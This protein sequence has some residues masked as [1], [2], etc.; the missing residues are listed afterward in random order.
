MS[1]IRYTHPMLHLQQQLNRMFEQFD[2]DLLG[3]LE[4]LGDGLF[5]PP[6]DVREDDEA[7]TVHLEVPGV[8]QQDLD[9]S[10]QD[11][12]LTIKGTKEQRQSEGR[13]R[14]I[15]RTYGSFVRT[16]SLP[17]NVDASNILANLQD[18]VLEVRLPKLEEARARQ[19]P[20]STTV[21][22]QSATVSGRK[23]ESGNTEAALDEQANSSA[24]QFQAEAANGVNSDDAPAGHPS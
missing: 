23:A 22:A 2:T 9:L 1:L 15:E 7:Y 6:V 20:V 12:V 3:G 5:A 13:Y 8:K 18:G 17:R 11:N 10:I 19:I 21:A 16:I 14:R 24:E 4:E